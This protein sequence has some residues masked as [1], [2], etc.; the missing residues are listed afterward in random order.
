MGHKQATQAVCMQA[1]AMLARMSAES[2]LGCNCASQAGQADSPTLCNPV[3]P[4]FCRYYDY[5]YCDKHFYICFDRYHKEVRRIYV[6]DLAWRS[7]QPLHTSAAGL[8]ARP[9]ASEPVAMDSY[10][11]TVGR[12]CAAAEVPPSTGECDCMQW[13]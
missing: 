5:D 8:P 11:S 10:S 12:S 4:T 2:L 7:V 9:A 3:P 1:G 13:Q 6:V